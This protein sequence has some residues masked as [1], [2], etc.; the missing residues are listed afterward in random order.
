MKVAISKSCRSSSSFP[1]K[2][3]SRGGKASAVAL[4]PAFGAVRKLE[5]MTKR[6]YFVVPAQAGT[7]AFQGFA[8]CS[9]PDLYP[10]VCIGQSP[11]CELRS[12]KK[13][14]DAPRRH[15]GHRGIVLN[16]TTSSYR[17]RPVSVV[18]WVPAFA[19]TT[20]VGGDLLR[21]SVLHSASPRRVTVSRAACGEW[22]G[23]CQGRLWVPAFAG[24]MIRE[25]MQLDYSLFR[26][27][28]R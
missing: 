27:G 13:A 21:V 8:P 28:R 14:E 9:C 4:A 1:R 5:F 11:T 24:T 19:G 23:S 17:R 7:Q 18:R 10:E 3:E 15:G 16:R 2:R 6:A 12:G 26:G 22:S 25:L 20:D